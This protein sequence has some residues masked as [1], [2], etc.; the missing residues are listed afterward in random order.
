MGKIKIEGY[1]CERC[2]HKWV[3]RNNKNN[4]VVCPNCKSPYWDKPRRKK[5]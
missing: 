4:P 2:G 3:S 5:K 1:I